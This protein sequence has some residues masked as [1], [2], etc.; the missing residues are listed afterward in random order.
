MQALGFLQMSFI[1]ANS[2]G[3]VWQWELDAEDIG[4]TRTL[5]DTLDDYVEPGGFSPVFGSFASLDRFITS[6]QLAAR[7]LHTIERPTEK[8]VAC[9]LKQRK[10]EFPAWVTLTYPNIPNYRLGP[11]D[12]SPCDTLGLDNLPV[13]KWRYEVDD[14]T[15]YT[16]HSLYRPVLLQPGSMA[17]GFRRWLDKQRNTSCTPVRVAWQVSCVPHS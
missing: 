10:F 17:L 16:G 7:K 8:G 4:A 5:I 14:S 11:L 6:R 12:G 3:K 2:Q 15:D 9:N 1:Y 13:A